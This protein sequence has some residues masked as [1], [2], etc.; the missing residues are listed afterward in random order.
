MPF[1]LDLP[2]SVQ[3]AANS[4]STGLS[5]AATNI[6]NGVAGTLDRIKSINPMDILNP[7]KL[8]L[9]GSGLLEG[10]KPPTPAVPALAKFEGDV[11]QWRVKISLADN[12]NYFYKGAT[13][14]E[15]GILEPLKATDGV[16][17]PYTP[18]ISI[19]HT[20]RY[21]GQQLTHSNYT[22]YSYEGSEVAAISVSGEFTAQNSTEAQYV[23]ACIHFLR[24]CTK[25]WWGSDSKAGNPPPIVFLDG[26]GDQ[27]LP[28]VPC[29]ITSFQHTMPPDV[30][31]IPAGAAFTTTSQV[32]VANSNPV[33]G[34]GG[35]SYPK[36][37]K[38][39][40]ATSTMIPTTSQIQVTLQP[41]Y[42]RRN[43]YDNFSLDA[44]AKG[45]LIKSDKGG[46]FI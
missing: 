46:G 43:I 29:V 21:G 9:A 40:T 24:S 14:V 17:F 31:Y 36:T 8:R 25:M 13:Y 35:G 12:A 18:T 39:A 45:A 6:S 22:N 32:A 16:V 27:Y 42:S 4:V 3:D 30:D 38:T 11:L 10:G 5:N 19:T 23:L 37:V 26:Y 28:H 2:Q 1:G 34:P 15:Q 41:I 7:G 44:F 20:A 33:T